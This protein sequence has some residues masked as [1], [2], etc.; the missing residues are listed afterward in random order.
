MAA[1]LLEL[2][3]YLFASNLIFLLFVPPMQPLLCAAV[4][5]LL[6][7]IAALIFGVATRS[8]TQTLNILEIYALIFCSPN[9]FDSSFICSV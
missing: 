2:L 5:T 9:L 3:S 1:T 7:I 8:P 4:L 6:I